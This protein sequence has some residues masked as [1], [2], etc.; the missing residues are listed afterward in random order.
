MRRW[1]FFLCCRGRGDQQLDGGVHLG[2]HGERAAV[3]GWGGGGVRLAHRQVA[4]PAVVLL[5]QQGAGPQEPFAHHPLLQPRETLRAG[6][7]QRH[8]RRVHASKHGQ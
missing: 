2:G 6:R 7:A 1:C 4:V 5:Q 3:G 8:P